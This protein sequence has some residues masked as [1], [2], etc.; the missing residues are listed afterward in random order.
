MKQELQQRL[1]A[2]RAFWQQRAPRERLALGAMM[3]VIAVAL[4][5]EGSHRLIERRDTLR[6]Q[7]ASLTQQTQTLTALQREWQSLAAAAVP[8]TEA[9]DERERILAAAT[10]LDTRLR[11]RWSDASTLNLQGEVDFD[12]W[13]D[14]L[15]R[16]HGEQGLSVRRSQFSALSTAAAAAPEPGGRIRLDAELVW[17]RASP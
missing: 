12:R 8:T 1:M 5:I 14:W 7:V 16:M 13:I 15:G 6:R 10:A 11:A 9:N 3:A 2:V 17:W 4:G